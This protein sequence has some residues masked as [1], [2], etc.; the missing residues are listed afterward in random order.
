MKELQPI[1]VNNEHLKKYSD[2]WYIFLSTL[3][4]IKN[5]ITNKKWKYINLKTSIKDHFSYCLIS[6]NR[7]LKNL[8]DGKSKFLLWSQFCLKDIFSC[9]ILYLKIELSTKLTFQEYVC[10]C[11]CVFVCK[12]VGMRV[13]V[14]LCVCVCVC[15]WVWVFCLKLSMLWCIL[16]I[17]KWFVTQ[18][19]P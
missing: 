13:G 15:V 4:D 19:I 17:L 3:D 7:S 14:C 11:V 9:Y 18:F 8:F 5:Q 2:I 6:I 1:P 12:C 16:Y 10:V